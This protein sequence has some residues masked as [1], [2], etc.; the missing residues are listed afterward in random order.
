MIGGLDKQS[1]ENNKLDLEKSKFRILE[2]MLKEARSELSLRTGMNPYNILP[3][4]SIN[5]MIE[6]QPTNLSELKGLQGWGLW[7]ISNFGKYFCDVICRFQKDHSVVSISDKIKVKIDTGNLNTG[8]S[9]SEVILIDSFSPKEMLIKSKISLSLYKP[10]YKIDDKDL[11]FSTSVP[12]V[13]ESVEKNEINEIKDKNS[14]VTIVQ[15]VKKDFNSS[16]LNIVPNSTTHV[17]IVPRFSS[18]FH[19]CKL[20]GLAQ[21]INSEDSNKRKISDIDDKNVPTNTIPVSISSAATLAMK[22]R[23]AFSGLIRKK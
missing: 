2:I 14:P 21:N 4:E 23:N 12:Q 6:K 1:E 18:S 7:K 11:S 15:G 16:Y 22:K 20:N 13:P 3:T 19:H 17:S 10:Q 8:K 5:A 9:K